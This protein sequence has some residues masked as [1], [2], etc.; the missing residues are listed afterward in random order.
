MSVTSPPSSP[1]ILSQES[2]PGM[3]YQPTA[4][5]MFLARLRLRSP[6]SSQEEDA[7]LALK[8]SEVKTDAHRDIVRPG[9]TIDFACL[10]V[11]GLAGR[12]DQLANGHRQITALH[13]PGDMCDLHSVAVP[14]TGWGIE[15]LTKTTTLRVA[16]APLRELTIQFPAIAFAFWRDT[17]ADA[18]ILSKWISALG[19]RGAKSRL[20]HLICEMGIR[21]EQAGLGT[22]THFRLPATQAQLADVLGLTAVHLNR[23]LQTLRRDGALF[24]EGFEVKV[25]DLNRL[26]GIAEFDPQYLLLES[27]AK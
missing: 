5:E 4:L 25:S 26:S 12:F 10:I 17:I 13:I 9:Q 15:A 27:G 8:G 2:K 23:T 24:T 22:R 6:L 1:G 21:M 14:H 20:A 19:R 11:D 18:S 3:T 7:I 16:H